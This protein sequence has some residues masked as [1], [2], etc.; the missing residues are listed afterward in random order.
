MKSEQALFPPERN[1][2]KHPLFRGAKL[3][4]KRYFDH[5][6]GH[7]SAAL[8]YYLIFALFPL[9]SFLSNLV[10]IFALDIEG[11]LLRFSTIIP[12]EVLDI[13]LQYL[14]YVNANSSRALLTFS[15]VFSIYFPFRA[16]NALLFSVRKAYGMEKP[17][18]FLRYQLK[19]L[20]FTAALL[21]T[22][23]LSLV[24]VVVGERVLIF[25]SS[26]IYLS[27]RFIALWG[28]LR[29]LF[30]GGVVFFA[31]AVLYALGQGRRSLRN[32]WPGVLLALSS[33][34]ALSLLFSLYVQNIGRYSL[35]YGAL[36]TIIV[37]LLWLYLTATLLIMGA[38]FNSVLLELR[39]ED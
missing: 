1:T 8:T 29:F 34:M 11:F 21:L 27:D 10:G 35:L 38:E 32:I 15:L 2:M 24:L 17:E 28:D 30:L 5:R 22:I 14:S 7:N 20:I 31:L 19:V 12:Q 39:S 6:V 36:G 3:L 16:A 23:P 13:A 4:I 26:Y 37:L 25:L 33:W 9:L 18:N